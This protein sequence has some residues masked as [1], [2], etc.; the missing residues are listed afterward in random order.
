L[1]LPVAVNALV[2]H[3][4]AVNLAGTSPPRTTTSGFTLDVSNVETILQIVLSVFWVAMVGRVVVSYRG[5]RR[6][7]RAVEVADERRG[8][9]IVRPS[10]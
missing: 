8:D 9:T 6:A 3:R 1:L 7:P 2:V 4:I 10:S 5:R